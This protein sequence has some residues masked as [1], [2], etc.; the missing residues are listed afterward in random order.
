MLFF[1]AATICPQPAQITELKNKSFTVV[2]GQAQ[3]P[4]KETIA[5]ELD[6]RLIRAKENEAEEKKERKRKLDCEDNLTNKTLKR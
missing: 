5:E 2:D 6:R 4:K 1:Q 3:S